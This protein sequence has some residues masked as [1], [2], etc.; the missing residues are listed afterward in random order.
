MHRSGGG[1]ATPVQATYAPGATITVKWTVVAGDGN[2]P[3]TFR[4]DT[5]GGQTFTGTA[6][7]STSAPTAD[8]VAVGPYTLT[9]T[10]PAG[11][12]CDKCTLQAKSS[13]NW[14][15]PLAP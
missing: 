11:V 6:I 4:L 12:T 7:P 9:L 13:T 5:A 15:V 14:L 2:G 10:L 8:I 1:A 3:V